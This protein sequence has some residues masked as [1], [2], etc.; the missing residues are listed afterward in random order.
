MLH[1]GLLPHSEREAVG[2]QLLEREVGPIMSITR[3]DA[4][5][6][7]PLLVHAGEKTYEIGSDGKPSE[8]TG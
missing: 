6:S 2:L 7:G 4:G 5:E 3:R 1:E 8:V